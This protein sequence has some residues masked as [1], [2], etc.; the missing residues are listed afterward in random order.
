MVGWFLHKRRTK[1]IALT[2]GPQPPH[3]ELE[4]KPNNISFGNSQYTTYPVEMD[5]GGTAVQNRAHTYEMPTQY[6]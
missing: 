3:Y 2:S 4:P 1:P 5:S 6:T